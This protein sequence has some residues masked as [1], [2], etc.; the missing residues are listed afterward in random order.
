[1]NVVTC[2]F[3][4]LDILAATPQRADRSSD[5]CGIAA[6][7]D[8]SLSDRSVLVTLRLAKHPKRM[9]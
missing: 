5:G 3:D 1:V 6:G 9:V 2:N 7:C 8:R 4:I